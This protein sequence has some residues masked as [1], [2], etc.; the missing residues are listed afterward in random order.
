MDTQTASAEMQ[1]PL[2]I[3]LTTV[4]NRIEETEARAAVE[5]LAKQVGVDPAAL[6]VLVTARRTGPAL[7][8]VTPPDDAASEALFPLEGLEEDAPVPTLSRDV[9]TGS[10]LVRV[11]IALMGSDAAD[12]II[13]PTTDSML[14]GGA[15]RHVT[16]FFQDKTGQLPIADASLF[17][18]C[19]ATLERALQREHPEC[20]VTIP[21]PP[22]WCAPY[23]GAHVS[24]C[25]LQYTVSTGSHLTPATAYQFAFGALAST[26]RAATI[27]EVRRQR[28][29]GSR[30]RVEMQVQLL[31]AEQ[32]STFRVAGYRL[33]DTGSGAAFER[34]PSRRATNGGKPPATASKPGRGPQPQRKAGAAAADATHFRRRVLTNVATAQR[35]GLCIPSPATYASAY[36]LAIAVVSGAG[37]APC[38]SAT[39]HML[40]KGIGP[41][42]AACPEGKGCHRGPKPLEPCGG[43]FTP[44]RAELLGEHASLPPFVIRP[45]GGTGSA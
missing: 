30:P 10:T 3:E 37:H 35:A 18:Q 5:Q 22:E 11:R 19:R 15:R 13:V 12:A 9:R 16:V 31:S 39:F 4:S 23:G 2:V 34:L 44:T 40:S 17:E 36:D 1:M 8:Y 41:A 26:P 20:D 29:A 6:I 24:R 28:L 43:C 7:A 27:G 21:R 32:R 25:C 33:K 14:T 38:A 42:E 45:G